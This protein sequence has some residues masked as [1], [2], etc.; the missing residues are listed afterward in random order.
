MYRASDG[1]LLQYRHWPAARPVPRAQ[2]VA[3]HGIQSHGGWYTYSCRRLADAGYEVSFL[4]RRGSGLNRCARGQAR[5]EDRL[6]NDVVQF[7]S[8]LQHRQ[9]QAGTTVPVVLMG[10]SWGG[11]LA[12]AVALKRPD[13][14]SA[15]AL[16]YPGIYSRLRTNWWQRFRLQRAEAIGWG[17]VLLPIPLNEPSLFTHD[18]QWQDFIRRDELALQQTSISFLLAN[19]RLTKFVDEHADHLTL[20]TLLMLAGRDEI[21]DNAATKARFARSNDGQ[22]TVI[23]YPEARHTLEFEPNPDR[24]IDD[25]LTWLETVFLKSER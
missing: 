18:P 20:P 13:L 17:Q 19:L 23:E 15:V 3:L 7:L 4:D 14:I 2:I 11:K 8:A 6:V 10:V 21:I 22:R 5:H 9:Q 16:L 1:Y 25:L 12:A 24:F